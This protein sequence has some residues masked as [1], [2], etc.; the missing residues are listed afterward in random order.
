[1]TEDR[2]PVDARIAEVE[3]ALRRY[4]ADIAPQVVADVPDMVRKAVRSSAARQSG[5][6]PRA[7][8]W[9]RR[10]V[11]GLAGCAAVVMGARAALYYAPNWAKTV[12]AAVEGI[13][14]AQWL[15][16]PQD[17]GL[18]R[19]AREGGIQ[20]LD[21][22]ATDNGL[23]VHVSGAYADSA[24]IVLFMRIDGAGSSG[25]WWSP[26]LSKVVITDQF[27][28]V[29]RF[30]SGHWDTETGVGELTF[31]G[32]PAWKLA[33]GLRL[34]LHIDEMVWQTVDGSQEEH[35]SGHWVLSWVENPVG[36]ERTV[37][38]NRS[39]S[40]GGVTL[41]LDTIL[42]TPG[43]A[44]FRLSGGRSVPSGNTTAVKADDRQEVVCL[45]TGERYPML[46]AGTDTYGRT[47]EMKVMTAPLQPGHRYELILHRVGEVT[48]TWVFPFTLS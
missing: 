17:R 35:R 30:S 16:L 22:S 43:S 44:E 26:D 37:T 6:W 15:I 8:R 18:A 41:R 11:V 45:D 47:V 38:V 31:D 27:G 48:G 33:L 19:L 9:F 14:G 2:Q 13:P 21:V 36:S 40:D 39:A 28:H 7:I 32:V 46:S 25:G 23:T 42:L 24:R 10:G 29:Y 5:G 20:T 4:F 12:Y 1:M 3:D 34:A